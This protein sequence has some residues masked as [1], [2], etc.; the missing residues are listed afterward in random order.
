MIRVVALQGAAIAPVVPELAALRITV[1]R[2]FP[3]LYDGDLDYEMSYLQSYVDSPAAIVAAAYDG[4]RLIGASTGLPMTDHEEAFGLPFRQ[5]G[6]ALDTIFYCA[7][8]LLLPQY[9]GQGIGH[10]FFDLREAQARGL[11]AK[12]VCF[13]AVERPADHPARPAEYRPLDGF[14]KKR[15]YAPLAE[16]KATFDWKDVG[17]D[18]E[19]AHTLQFWMRD[20]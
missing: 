12:H 10:K 15:G 14:W 2:A 19:T 9:R 3:Y 1:F 8:S 7:E 18:E 11:G 20:L 6:Y 4:D 5:R 13:C 17:D 16:V